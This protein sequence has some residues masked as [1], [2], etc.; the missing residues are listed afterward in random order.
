MS[1]EWL[2][3]KKVSNSVFDRVIY[4]NNKQW[5]DSHRTLHQNL[6]DY[7]YVDKYI[8]KY[9]HEF[10]THPWLNFVFHCVILVCS[11]LRT[12]LLASPAKYLPV[13]VSLGCRDEIRNWIAVKLWK[14][15]RKLCGKFDRSEAKLFENVRDFL[16]TLNLCV[17]VWKN[18]MH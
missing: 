12:R 1:L 5:S 7:I 9:I 6:S 17:L 10:S 8:C 11:G 2:S 3:L 18:S 16:C 13:F 15:F 14:R 4:K